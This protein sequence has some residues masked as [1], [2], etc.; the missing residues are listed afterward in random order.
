MGLFCR[1]L[2]QK[3]PIFLSILLIAAT[4]YHGMKRES[5]IGIYDLIYIERVGERE[6]E[7]VYIESIE[8]ES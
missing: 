4:P 8:R 2:L 7:R 5:A 3:R 1:A 6:R